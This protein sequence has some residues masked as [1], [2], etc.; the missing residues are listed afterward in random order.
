MD[1]AEVVL[2][3]ERLQHA[4]KLQA[5]ARASGLHRP[6]FIAVGFHRPHLPWVAPSEFYDLYPP[7]LEM[8]GTYNSMW[9]DSSRGTSHRAEAAGEPSDININS[10]TSISLMLCLL[11]V[12]ITQ[13]R[14]TQ[15]SL[16]ACQMWRG[17]LGYT[18]AAST[19]HAA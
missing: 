17:I 15:Q 7:A 5:K 2:A 8:P 1:Q 19:N 4:A 6:F 14:S 16:R 11:H 3:K 13:G 9:I 12:L 18:P 10:S